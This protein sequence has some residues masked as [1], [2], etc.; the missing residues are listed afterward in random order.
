[1]S[2]LL[3]LLYAIQLSLFEVRYDHAKIPASYVNSFNCN[4][5]SLFQLSVMAVVRFYSR[6][7]VR[8]RALQRAAQL[9]PKLSIIGEMCYNVELTG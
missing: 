4:I 9:Y 5:C 1:M 2:I 7:A 6:E 8:G 3:C